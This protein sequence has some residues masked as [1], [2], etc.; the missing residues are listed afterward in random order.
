M[1]SS[2]NSAE[3]HKNWL[4]MLQGIPVSSDSTHATPPTESS[5]A[6]DD[7]LTKAMQGMSLSSDPTHAMPPIESSSAVDNTSRITPKSASL[8]GIPSELRL[9]IFSHAL[10]GATGPSG[11]VSVN[12]HARL[13]SDPSGA[14]HESCD[15]W[16]KQTKW[17][18]RRGLLQTCHEIR[19][20]ALEVLYNKNIFFAH[21]TRCG[22]GWSF[23]IERFSNWFKSMGGDEE[24]RRVRKVTFGAKWV[25]LVQDI[26]D[27]EDKIG[28]VNI[29][30]FN[31]KV[32][33][34]GSGDIVESPAAPLL[35]QVDALIT[36]FLVGRKMGEGLG[37]AEWMLVWAKVQEL[38]TRGWGSPQ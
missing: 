34:G 5:S 10:S 13:L 6:V 27:R 4:K 33:V 24:I 11:T 1:L 29:S 22:E 28:D 14:W 3:A 7:S 19:E 31:G 26:D 23:E 20:E 38:T 30:I 8:M 25:A 17:Q 37:Y 9:Q 32:T 21:V 35:E 2:E 15:S 16:G 36:T 12:P 18:A